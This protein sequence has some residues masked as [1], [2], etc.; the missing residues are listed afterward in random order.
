M[1]SVSFVVAAAT[2]AVMLAL[3]GCP[4]TMPE[5]TT[6]T[7]DTTP[8]APT[9]Q[10]YTGTLVPT[11][12]LNDPSMG[13]ITATI[14]GITR[15]DVAVEDPALSAEVALLDGLDAEPGINFSYAISAD[16]TMITV[17]GAL[18]ESL[19]LPGGMVEAT[20]SGAPVTDPTEALFGMWMTPAVEDPETMA[21]TLTLMITPP[22]A[23]DAP[24]G[25]TLTVGAAPASS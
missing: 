9:I 16:F 5:D 14:T 2:V 6:D 13:M 10:V 15:D 22:D 25:F 7:T 21:P 18:L 20:R 24:I 1:K 11:P 19:M 12:D 8:A 23:S 4:G 3:A 17:T